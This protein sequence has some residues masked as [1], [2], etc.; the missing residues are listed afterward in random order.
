MTLSCCK[1][2]VSITERNIVSKIFIVQ[3]VFILILQKNKLKKHYNV[4][5]KVM[6]IVL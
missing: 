3:I 1:E 5:K 4:C 6:A 2:N